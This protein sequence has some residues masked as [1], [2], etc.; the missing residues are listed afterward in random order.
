M[1][2]NGK[3]IIK[4]GVI[5]PYT[6]G[7]EKITAYYS[8]SYY[9]SAMYLALDDI[10]N[11]PN[12]LPDHQ[13]T[14]VWA[15]SKCS[16]TE[17][18][19]AQYKMIREQKV[20]A[21]IGAGCDDCIIT[22]R[23]AGAFNIPIVSHM[24]YEPELSNKSRY[25][26]FARTE[27]VGRQ[28]TPAIAELLHYFKWHKFALVVENS[29]VYRR[30]GADIL[31]TFGERINAVKYMKT[32]PQYAYESH[33]QHVKNDIKHISTRARI[34]ILLTDIR[35][36]KECLIAAYELQLTQKGDHVFVAFEIDII[37][38][39]VRQKKAFK[40][41]TADFTADNVQPNDFHK[42]IQRSKMLCSA[43]ES[44]LL[45]MTKVPT[46]QESK[47]K[48]DVNEFYNRVRDGMKIWFNSTVYE[49]IIQSTNYSKK[50][51]QPPNHAMTLYD[52][53]MVYAI[54]VNDTLRK[55]QDYRDGKVVMRHLKNNVFGSIRGYQMLFD[56]NGE[57][58]Y[59]F[60][61]Y[62]YGTVLNWE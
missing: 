59:P 12:I 29:T 44:A 20:D 53:I 49:G 43:W 25:P 8:G 51:A 48:D 50:T 10:N 1:D 38:G 61:L 13:L 47:E 2:T 60:V 15:N 16:F 41:A 58:Q 32:S 7:E 31:H 5:I 37:S 33:Y 24:C 3:R 57:V 21:F 11:N 4:I 19:K 18:V 56:E 55:G 40:W 30:A 36:A 22:A 28:L 62:H 45:M 46:C 52:A 26:T 42:F 17:S 34:I 27:P 9:A 23:N 39:N 54:T 35:I 14:L 6:F